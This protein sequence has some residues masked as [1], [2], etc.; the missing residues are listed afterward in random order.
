[1]TVPR[2]TVGES[3]RGSSRSRKGSKTGT[4]TRAAK[5]VDSDDERSFKVVVLPWSVCLRPLLRYPCLTNRSLSFL[6]RRTISAPS[7][8]RGRQTAS[9]GQACSGNTWQTLAYAF[10]SPP[11]SPSLRVFAA[12]FQNGHLSQRPTHIHIPCG[13]IVPVVYRHSTCCFFQ[14]SCDKTTSSGRPLSCQHR[15]SP[16]LSPLL[17]EAKP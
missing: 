6:E 2:D 13:G 17:Q 10:P 7:N 4:A 1:M 12:P 15:G 3:S 9:S 5:E 16:R 11:T 8:E 14:G